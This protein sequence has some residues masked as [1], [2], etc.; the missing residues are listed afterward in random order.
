MHWYFLGSQAN[1]KF[2]FHDKCLIFHDLWPCC[3]NLFGVFCMVSHGTFMRLLYFSLCVYLYYDPFEQVTFFQPSYSKL[4]NITIKYISDIWYDLWYFSE[5]N[6][7]CKSM[8]FESKFV[9]Q[10]CTNLVR[11]YLVGVGGGGS[12]NKRFAFLA[13]SS[14]WFIEFLCKW[15]H[16]IAFTIMLIAT[17]PWNFQ[18]N[19]CIYP[20][21]TKNIIHHL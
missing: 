11:K 9:T 18:P 7:L 21:M 15:T 2:L 3:H 6:L 8:D 4:T 13:F 16:S 19:F 10:M 1:L 20:K 14:V 12:Q 5:S 17:M